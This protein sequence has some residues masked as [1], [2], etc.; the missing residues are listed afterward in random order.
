MDSQKSINAKIAKKLEEQGILLSSIAIKD[1]PDETIVVV[2]VDA[3]HATATQA[4]TSEFDQIIEAAGLR[5]FATVRSRPN[6]TAQ[7]KTTNQTNRV[8]GLSTL[9]GDQALELIQVLESRARTSEAGPA[10]DY[11][12]DAT[13]NVTSAQ[14]PRHHLIFGRRGAG[15]TAMLLEA[16]RRIGAQGDFSI[17]LNIQTRRNQSSQKIFSAACIQIADLAKREIETSRSS[18]GALQQ[19]QKL[20]NA[21]ESANEDLTVELNTTLKYIYDTLGRRFY[22][23]LDDLHYL[24]RNQQPELLELFHAGSRDANCW[25][26]IATIKHLSRWYNP[27]KQQGLQLGHDAASL[28]LDLTLQNPGEAKSFLERMLSAHAHSVNINRLTNVFSLEALDRLVFAAGAV[29]RDYMM[30]SSATVK[31]ARGRPQARTV[32]VEDVNR[33]AGAAAQSK[34]T[35]LEDDAASAG[36]EKAEVLIALEKITKF[37]TE[38]QQQTFFRID[39]SDKENHPVEYGLLQAL[40]DLRLIHLVSS[41]VSEPH[42]A[43]RKAEAFTMDLS[44]YTG[45]RLKKGLKVL[46][47]VGGV[48]VQKTTGTTQKPKRGDTSRNLTAILRVSPL[49]EL[50]SLSSRKRPVH[51]R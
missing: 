47:F 35:E 18:S 14:G 13:Y 50:A 44:R 29:P 4:L 31:K 41:S 43:G 48:L 27:Q 30:L 45:D 40:L 34:I 1:Y 8:V 42:E 37:C 36:N 2:E 28:D 12:P 3:E 22:I 33:A 11:I 5:G 49:F 39:F 10:F 15:K 46:D 9:K 20:R 19:V 51:K 21:A 38:D 16:R 24:K 17:W 26:K 32:G 23:F 6:S 7:N 25:L